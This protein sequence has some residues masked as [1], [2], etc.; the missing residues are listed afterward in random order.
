MENKMKFMMAT[1]AALGAAFLTTAHAGTKYTFEIDNPPGSSAAGDI[2]FLS[3]SYD[4]SDRLSYEVTLNNRAANGGYLVLS[5]RNN[6][7]NSAQELAIFYF[8]FDRKN[9]HVYEYDGR[10]SGSS[11]SG[12][13]SYLRQQGYITT[14]ENALTVTDTGAGQTISFANLDV[15]A[16]APGTQ[17]ADWTGA[18]FSDNVGIWAG[19]V[20]LN[21]FETTADGRLT[22]FG[23][24][25]RSWYDSPALPTTSTEVSEPMGFAIAGLLM[26]GGLVSWRRRSQKTA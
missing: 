2:Q 11:T 4:S 5:P 15:S 17:G 20:T 10:Y 1:F 25:A 18:S 9:L 13:N 23:I 21:S 8:D 24:A 16:I 6:P 14:Y 7:K 26:V 19:L 22:S 12:V 3:V